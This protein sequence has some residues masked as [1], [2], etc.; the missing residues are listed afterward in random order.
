MG[1]GIMIVAEIFL[2]NPSKMFFGKY[3]HVVETFA[4]DTADA[5]RKKLKPGG[6]HG[7]KRFR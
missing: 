5:R 4:A 2:Q 3:N 6:S 7:G 1:P